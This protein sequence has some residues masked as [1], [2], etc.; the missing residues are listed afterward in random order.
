MKLVADNSQPGLLVNPDWQAGQPGTF[1]VIMGASRYRWLA[2]GGDNVAAETYGLG[3]LAVSALTAFE[4]FRWLT[5]VY[6]FAEAPLARCWLML[7]PT[8]AEQATE[9]GL[10]DY[11]AEP[12]FDN[13]RKALGYWWDTMRSLPAA[14]AS[15]S[16]ALFFFS[17]HGIEIYQDKQI[18]LPCDYLC[19]P[20]RSWND[21]ISTENLK[22]ALASLAVP[23]QFFF[24]DACR[25][26]NAELRRK[27]VNGSSILNE[28]Q[29]DLVNPDLVA[30]LMYATSSGQQAFQQPDPGKGLSLFGS[31]LLDGLNGKPEI[32]LVHHDPDYAVNLYALQAFVKQ[33]VRELLAKAGENVR[34]PVQMSGVVDDATVTFLKPYT[35]R[36][37]R[38]NLE[39]GFARDTALDKRFGAPAAAVPKELPSDLPTAFDPPPALIQQ[40]QSG[41]ASAGHQ[42]FGSEDVTELWLPSNLSV[43]A[44]GA[45]NWI[46]FPF[47]T[48]HRIERTTGSSGSNGA[49]RSYRVEIAFT[50]PD[51]AGYWLEIRSAHDKIWG[52][53]LPSPTRFDHAGLGLTEPIHF[54][55][56][57]D[58]ASSG[59]FPAEFTRF[60]ASLATSNPGPLGEAARLWQKYRNGDLGEAIRVFE[61]DA[62]NLREIVRA[63]LDDPLAALVAAVVLMRGRRSDLLNDWLFNLANW[64]PQLPDGCILWSEHLMRK[65]A[66]SDQEKQ[67]SARSLS[68]LASR[69]LPFT[70]EGFSY[71]SRLV[72]LFTGIKSSYA[73]E[74]VAPLYLL[75]DRLEQAVPYLRP[76]GLFTTYSEM[77]PL[78]GPNLLG[79]DSH[80]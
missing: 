49:A 18:L 11:P 73:G 50:I 6:S 25:N 65:Q 29:S 52:C 20:A 22:R 69:P 78:T 80:P 12:T 7:A 28:D 76:G 34:Q 62:S 9:S 26:G 46:T 45:K 68:L 30:P 54:L 42:I 64:F 8:A 63:K 55:L 39:G 61:E 60:E 15:R 3:Q 10:A 40:Y 57:F 1:A 72:R 16:R 4:W 43:Y 2:G 44:I 67:G 41:D 56:D 59:A 79:L 47:L 17:G 31:A 13:C 5:S 38:T 37:W 66:A 23:S 32:T 24:L 14:A 77:Q 74:F 70:S 51:Q 53:V 75:A 21:A 58:A 36:A 27:V 48:I 33:R 19:P 71:A 35:I